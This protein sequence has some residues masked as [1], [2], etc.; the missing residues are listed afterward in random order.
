MER[1]LHEDPKQLVGE[2]FREKF[3]SDHILVFYRLF[4]LIPVILS[5]EWT[6][7]SDDFPQ[8]EGSSSGKFDADFTALRTDYTPKSSKSF[9]SYDELLSKKFRWELTVY[10]TRMQRFCFDADIRLSELYGV[11]KQWLK[12]LE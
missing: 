5:K 2:F 7:S 6:E 1:S 12:V 8:S 10:S 4:L 3:L 9:C 11:L